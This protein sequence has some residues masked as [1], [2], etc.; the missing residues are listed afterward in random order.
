MGYFFQILGILFHVS[1]LKKWLFKGLSP[2]SRRF[3]VLAPL[4]ACSGSDGVQEAASSN[5]A[6]PT[7]R[8]KY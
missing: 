4:P 8:K 3:G 7:S 5:L 2:F 6:T 1:K